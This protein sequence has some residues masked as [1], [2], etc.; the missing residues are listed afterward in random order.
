MRDEVL[1][2]GGA[3]RPHWREFV[4]GMA[5]MAPEEF[6]R[7]WDL[8]QRL[9][10]DNGVTY[11]VYGDPAGLDRPWQLD[12]VP[13][14]L[15]SD[16]WKGLSE[17]IVQ[18][19]TLLDR[20]LADLYGERRLVADGLIPSS[21][22]HANPNLLRPCHGWTP[23]GGRW[24]HHYAADLARGRDGRWRVVADRCETPAGAG[25][26]LENRLIVS[27]VLPEIHRSLHVERLGPFFEA[28]RRSLQ[29]VSPRNVDDPRVVLLTPG[30]YNATYFEHAYLARHLGITLVQGEDLTVR[31]NKVYLKALTGLQQV[32]VIFRRTGGVW[33]DPLELRGDSTLGIAGMVQSARAGNVAIVNA[34]GSGLL[35]GASMM[36]YLP[37]ISTALLGE[38]LKM[39]SVITLWCGE[40][41]A[42]DYVMSNLSGLVLR[43]AFGRREAPQVGSAL[44]EAQLAD[45]RRDILAR[46]WEWVAQ[47]MEGMGTV[48]VWNQGLFR[49][50]H[51]LL[52]VF[53]VATEQGW[54][55]MP[56]G[57]ARV[58]DE[59]DLLASRLQGSGSRDGG[60]KDVWIRADERRDPV[61]MG[62]A[63]KPALP[64]K[65]TRDN[66]DLPSR[67][68]DNM[69]WL[70]R[71]F[72]RCEAT[73]RLLRTALNNIE[74]ALDQGDSA[75]PP[76][77]LRTVG[78]LSLGIPPDA[79]DD[80]PA[81][82][83][84]RLVRHH[85]GAAQG[86]LAVQVE[87]LMR[88]VT[89]LRDRLSVDTWRALQHLRDEVYRLGAD[90]QGGDAM[91]RLNSMVLI[92]E[93][94]SGLSM[95]NM[96]R[97]YQWVFLDSGRRI[98]RAIAI[99]DTVGGALSGA[100]GEDDLPL[101]LLLEIWDSVM[102]YRSRYL[103]S[104]RLAGVLDLL[105]SDETNPRSLGFQLAVLTRHVDSLA[106]AGGPSDFLRPE[107]R[108]MTLLFGSVRTADVMA[109]SR[110]DDDAKGFYDAERQMGFLRSRLW[111]LSNDISR[112][113]FSH[114]QWRLPTR[115]M[116]LLP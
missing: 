22:L 58:S 16:E 50:Q 17:G 29:E 31:D 61:T 27:R 114:A 48:P 1:D 13:L 80:G 113:Y 47:A 93:A 89:N 39:P 63:R 37:G 83:P 52:R 73:V 115:H 96:T 91:G 51:S 53:A 101:D 40:A 88:V 79:L 112:S 6:V 74:M 26:A 116:E 95:E 35:D 34:L 14:I 4:Q 65:L 104:P 92:M 43:K 46:P 59:V 70:G 62:A 94:I 7:R 64:V 77:I 28:L 106:V 20:I 102:T 44:S 30:P 111:E 10:S 87:T 76:K 107:Q 33:C 85:L 110:Y 19:A 25:Y 56:G 97:G 21:L 72:E 68:A 18:R 67:V 81:G 12:P 105:L 8:G 45:L 100:A 71:Y 98:E 84:G 66:R 57:L 41:E 82:V 78:K 23:A 60:S 103:V 5:Q 99:V 38:P 24:L 49:P 86:G 36:G 15:P 109:L 11:N 42:L 32:D 9:I 3:L 69:Y 54:Q 108:Q 55:V 90:V 75:Q 2:E